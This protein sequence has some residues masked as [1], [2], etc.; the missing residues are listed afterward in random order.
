MLY[1]STVQVVM[2]LQEV[3]YRISNGLVAWLLRER[4]IAAPDK[5]PGGA[6][7]W[8]LPDIERLESEL[9]RRGRGPE[10]GRR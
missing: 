10:G 1:K 4:I 3:G 2:E 9:L 5:G 7:L 8:T 6:F